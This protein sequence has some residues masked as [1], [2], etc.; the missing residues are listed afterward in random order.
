MNRVCDFVGPKTECTYIRSIL[1]Y[2]TDTF[3]LSAHAVPLMQGSD[4]GKQSFD[5]QVGGF[6]WDV[7]N[8]GIDVVL[9]PTECCQRL[10]KVRG[11][12]H[13]RGASGWAR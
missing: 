11:H 7:N 6:C 3:R 9:I 2:T 10:G 1:S 4:C 8:S 13:A 5:A 12:D